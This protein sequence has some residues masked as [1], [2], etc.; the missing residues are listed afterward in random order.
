MLLKR[1]HFLFLSFFLLGCGTLAKKSSS[2]PLAERVPY[3][4]PQQGFLWVFAM[5]GSAQSGVSDV[6]Y[7]SEG[8]FRQTQGPFECSVQIEPEELD[9]ERKTIQQKAHLD[10]GEKRVN[11]VCETNKHEEPFEIQI[12]K[13]GEYLKAILGCD[14]GQNEVPPRTVF[15]GTMILS[16]AVL[17]PHADESTIRSTT[18]FPYRPNQNYAWIMFVSSD[19]KVLRVRTELTYEKPLS[20]WP[21]FPKSLKV[22][23]D[24]RSG[25]YEKILQSEN[26]N[27]ILGD[28]YHVAK[29]DPGGPL[30]IRV[31]IEDQL[32]EEYW[33][34]F[35]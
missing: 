3:S 27:F 21:G 26:G 8:A 22:S 30:R 33:L 23:A 32:A 5:N 18:V 20:E 7:L 29:S 19:R 17:E 1:I 12:G 31:Y 16:S 9:I 6:H 2:S 10:C 13:N 25:S 11:T 24:G 14:N 28:Q 4:R 15:P 34:R 35:L